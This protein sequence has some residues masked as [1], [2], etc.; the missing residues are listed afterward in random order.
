MDGRNIY[1]TER[2]FEDYM[3]FSFKKY[4]KINTKIYRK[5]LPEGYGKYNAEDVGLPFDLFIKETGK[6]RGTLLCYVYDEEKKEFRGYEV[7]YNTKRSKNENDEYMRIFINNNLELLHRMA[8]GYADCTDFYNERVGVY[9]VT[10][11][12]EYDTDLDLLTEMAGLSR[13]TT[14]LKMNLWV[15]EGGTYKKGGHWQRLKFDP[16]NGKDKET[17]QFPS[18]TIEDEPRVIKKYDNQIIK[19][20]PQDLEQLKTFVKL[21]K[22]NL[23]AMGDGKL[24]KAHEFIPSMV[25]FDGHGNLKRPIPFGSTEYTETFTDNFGFTQLET[26]DENGKKRYNFCK[27]SGTRIPCCKYWFDK[28]TG[29]FLTNDKIVAWGEIND[30]KYYVYPDGRIQV[31][32]G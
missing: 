32:R 28:L 15:D 4:G 1:L 24:H 7:R 2:Q 22:D 17:R 9:N 18:I 3:R 29:F 20:K 21:N 12:N 8:E 14:G 13:R 16:M 27:G 6:I 25:T 23:L 11:D 5:R 19:L 10:D 30:I 31:M 26:T